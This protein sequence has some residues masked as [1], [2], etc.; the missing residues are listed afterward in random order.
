[1][2]CSSCG[3]AVT[4]GLSYCNRCGAKLV[5]KKSA[6][7]KD[8][9]LIE[10][11]VWAIVGVSVGGLALLIGMMAVMKH[12]LQFENQMILLVL[13]LS[14]VP[15]LAAEIIFIWLLLRSKS[16]SGAREQET[17]DIAQLK[18]APKELYEPQ[19]VLL[20]EPAVSVTEETTRA[21]EP[22][23]RKRKDE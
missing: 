8:S 19:E 4:P 23:Y 15:L 9:Q 10:S 7:S 11:L 16:G 20:T 21:L 5:S 2:Y 13:L 14:F 12:E 18:K 1:M 22:V 17:A 3:S 6:A